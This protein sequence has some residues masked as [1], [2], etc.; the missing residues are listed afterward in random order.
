[1]RTLLSVEK[2]VFKKLLY[3]RVYLESSPKMFA[4]YEKK[5]NLLNRKHKSDIFPSTR[6]SFHSK[7]LD[8]VFLLIEVCKDCKVL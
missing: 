2:K 8:D 1:M 3:L 5:K 7:S 6:T 4:S